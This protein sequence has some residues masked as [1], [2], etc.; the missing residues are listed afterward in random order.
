MARLH[1]G[2][3]WESGRRPLSEIS[4]KDPGPAPAGSELD[5]LFDTLTGELRRIWEDRTAHEEPSPEY[6]IVT[7]GRPRTPSCQIRPSR[8][9]ASLVTMLFRTLGPLVR[10]GRRDSVTSPVN[11]HRSSGSLWSL[12]AQALTPIRSVPHS[13]NAA[14]GGRVRRA[15]VQPRSRTGA[16]HR[17]DVGSRSGCGDRRHPPCLSSPRCSRTT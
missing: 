10:R 5:T 1:L 7:Y 2:H 16:G 12:A 9:A 8:P 11:G 4:R 15:R 13:P 6:G 3:E 17:S 14:F